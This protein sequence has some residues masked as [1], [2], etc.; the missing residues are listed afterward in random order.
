MRRQ[1]ARGEHEE[2]IASRFASRTVLCSRKYTGSSY[3]TERC[4]PAMYMVL[5]ASL[6]PLCGTPTGASKH[7]PKGASWP[8]DLIGRKV[9][10]R[11]RRHGHTVEKVGSS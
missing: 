9:K 8:P 2:T 3:S 11:T 4:P 5:C 6:S 1:Q 10:T 7:V